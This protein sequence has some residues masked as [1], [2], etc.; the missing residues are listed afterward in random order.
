[1]K[2]K[3]VLT[4][5]S[6]L[7]AITVPL[8]AAAKT[9]E[10]GP[11]GRP[12][13]TEVPVVTPR[14]KVTPFPKATPTPTPAP[15]AAPSQPTSPNTG[16]GTTSPQVSS[17]PSAVPNPINTP[18]P[19]TTAETTATPAATPSPAPTEG[20]LTLVAEAD[21]GVK[22]GFT[23]SVTGTSQDGNE[24]SRDYRTDETG[25]VVLSIPPGSYT[26][27]PKEGSHVNQGYAIP[28]GQ[29]FSITA[30][31]SIYLTFYFTATQRNLTLTV[32]DD[33][34]T[35]LENVT[36]GIYAVEDLE[37]KPVEEEV[38]IKDTTDITQKIEESSQ[39]AVEEERRQNP[40]DRRNALALGKTDIEGKVTIE[41]VPVTDLV[42]VAIDVPTG[43]TLE[44][45]PTDIPS[46]LDTEFEVLCEY[47]KV[48]LEIINESTGIPVVDAEAVLYDKN[49]EELANWLTE[50]RPHRL[51]RVPVGEYSL[52]IH[53]EDQ[54]DTIALTVANDTTLQDM[55]LTT[56]IQGAAVPEETQEGTNVNWAG[57]LIGIVVVAALCVAGVFGFRWFREYRK[58]S[59][60]YQ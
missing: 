24:Y 29:Q 49:G 18:V 2:R 53:Y 39:A 8:A 25:Q 40:Y 42:A 54:T 3:T 31:E 44:M 58:R 43:Y 16:N 7:L 10:E 26:A 14:P 4:L 22:E 9:T 60:G 35:P 34:D 52:D 15:T 56:F 37:E 48:D 57:I 11:V 20:T 19:G 41:E 32:V 23:I 50:G 46:G 12:S 28:D 38:P 21:N 6:L 30:G 45:V 55:E 5:L 36:I 59:G 47:L 27:V 51:I 17:S 1:M 13:V 33:D